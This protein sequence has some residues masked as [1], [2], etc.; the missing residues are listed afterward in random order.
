MVYPAGIITRALTL[1]VGTRFEDGQSLGIQATVVASRSLVWSDG[2]PL[3]ASGATLT[4]SDG[5]QVTFQLPVTDQSGYRDTHGGVITLAPGDHTHTYTIVGK[6]TKGQSKIGDIALGP[7][8]VSTG[9]G[10]PIDVDELAPVN[11]AVG[12]PAV[13]IVDQWSSQIDDAV[14][15]A[16]DAVALANGKEPAGLSSSTRAGLE[17]AGLS[18]ATSQKIDFRHQVAVGALKYVPAGTDPTTTDVSTY[19]QQVINEAAA[20]G[21]DAVVWLPPFAIIA[22]IQVKSNVRIIGAS[23]GRSSLKAVPGSSNPGVVMLD[24]T[25]GPV[26]RAKLE[27]VA[28]SGNTANASQWGIYLK[29]PPRAVSPFDHGLWYTSFRDIRITNTVAGGIWLYGGGTDSLGPHQFLN[30]DQV[31]I[32]Y[33]D[34]TVTPTNWIG[35][36]ATGQVGQITWNQIESSYRGTGFGASAVSI[37]RETDD[38]QTNVSDKAPYAMTFNAST[39][40]GCAININVERAA[41]IQFN[42]C[43]VEDGQNGFRV[44]TAATGVQ[45][46]ACH[47]ADTTNNGG[48][49]YVGRVEGTCQV[50]VTDATVANSGTNDLVWADATAAGGSFQID[51]ADPASTTKTSGYPKQLTATGTLNVGPNAYVAVTGATTITTLS[52]NLPHGAILVLRLTSAGSYNVASGNIRAGIGNSLYG[53][54]SVISFPNNTRLEF[55]FDKGANIYTLVS[56]TSVFMPTATGMVT[57]VAGTASVGYTPTTANAIVRLNRQAAGGTL[58]H[59]SVALTAGTGFA[60]NSSSNTDTSTVFFEVLNP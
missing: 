41:G 34:A 12:A 2:T 42:A 40:Q 54:S 45:F 3:V 17:P 53:T 1:G 24:Q 7:F 27:N 22:E 57:L 16:A 38:T 21:G 33:T 15:A 9:D 52:S 48:T 19:V 50:T 44:R 56:A 55:H 20:S 47:F 30:F 4:A 35:I 43:W 36:L 60:I 49:G 28:I 29:C 26:T 51:G 5:A 23:H 6:F 59:L 14:S 58:G 37:L 39:F 13:S 11:G 8:T 18:T 46:N 10:S 32:Q 25:G 31:S